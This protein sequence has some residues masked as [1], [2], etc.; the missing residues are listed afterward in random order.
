M[1]ETPI[2]ATEAGAMIRRG[3]LSCVELTAAAIER[4]DTLD[5][6]LS[7]HSDRDQRYSGHGGRADHGQ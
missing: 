6:R 5:P 2:T 1:Q 3:E 4:A 7:R